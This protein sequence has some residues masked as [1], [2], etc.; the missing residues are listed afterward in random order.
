M[1]TFLFLAISCTALVSSI[2]LAKNKI[3]LC[4]LNKFTVAKENS[5]QLIKPKF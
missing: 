1:D 5:E 2:C 4:D 3:K